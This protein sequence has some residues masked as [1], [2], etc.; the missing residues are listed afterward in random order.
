[1]VVALCE[2]RGGPNRCSRLG[3]QGR[4]PRVAAAERSC[5]DGRDGSKYGRSL[6]RAHHAPRVASMTVDGRGVER[7]ARRGATSARTALRA[8][9]GEC[10][11]R[12]DRSELS[13]QVFGRAESARVSA[14]DHEREPRAFEKWLERAQLAQACVTKSRVKPERCKALG[15]DCAILM[16][17]SRKSSTVCRSRARTEEGQW[18]AAG[19]APL[20]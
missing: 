12:A 10:P 1:M 3:R 16:H 9:V 20:R 17:P 4:R 13:A 6:C 11:G 5:T 7:R 19:S 2:N 8:V 15:C 14:I 18:L